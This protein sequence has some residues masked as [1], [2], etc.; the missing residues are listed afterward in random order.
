VR[1][2]FET[3]HPL[4]W[5]VQHTGRI[6]GTVVGRIASVFDKDEQP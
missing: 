3:D 4:V 5:V 6:A 1:A 2:R